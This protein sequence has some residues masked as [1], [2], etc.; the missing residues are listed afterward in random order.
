VIGNLP[1]LHHE[2]YIEEYWNMSDINQE[3]QDTEIDPELNLLSK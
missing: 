1:P 3:N 2:H